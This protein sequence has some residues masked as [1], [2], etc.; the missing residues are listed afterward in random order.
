M[1]PSVEKKKTPSFSYGSNK[2]VVR[3][4]RRKYRRGVRNTIFWQRVRA[5]KRTRANYSTVL[6]GVANQVARVQVQHGPSRRRGNKR[7]I[8]RV[9]SVD[10]F[11]KSIETGVGR[12]YG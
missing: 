12:G 7:T 1:P 6:C 5:R 4:R 10:D 8:V 9:R 3:T 11:A 2:R